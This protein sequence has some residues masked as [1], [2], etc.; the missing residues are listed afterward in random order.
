[1]MECIDWCRSKEVHLIS[2]EIYAGSVYR[3][4]RTAPLHWPSGQVFI[5]GQKTFVSAMS[6]GAGGSNSD[7]STTTDGGVGLGL[8]P[9]IHLVYAFS[10]DFALSGLRVG[11]AYTENDEILLPL[12]KLN[13]LCQ[14]SSQTQLLVE[15]MLCANAIMGDGDVS[16]KFVDVYL[17]RNQD[18]IRDRC[19]MLQSCLDELDIPYLNADSGLF[20]WM[21]FREFLP[22]LP[23]GVTESTETIESKEQRERQL[24][25][26]LMKEY[27]LLFTPGMSM[28]NER[29]G[30][31]RCVF[32]A[33]SEDEFHL[34]LER[35]R[36]FVD[37]M[38]KK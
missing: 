18:N 6:L 31:F 7:T 24:Y 22:K 26:S 35:L 25:L 23:S 3:E 14:I 37:A 15:R 29:A 20:V 27:G 9:Y 21:D 11:V 19:D 33:A 34:G 8:G 28:R 32:T 13:D 4:D 30:F 1:M 16:Q 36:K 2:D 38:R 5:E 17:K 10:K 12:Q